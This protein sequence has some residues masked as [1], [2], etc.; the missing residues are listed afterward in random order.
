MTWIKPTIIVR[1]LNNGFDHLFSAEHPE[2]LKFINCLKRQQNQA[3]GIK[4]APSAVGNP[5]MPRNKNKNKCVIWDEKS[6]IILLLYCIKAL[7]FF[8]AIIHR[9]NYS[10]V[11]YIDFAIYFNGDILVTRYLVGN[12][13]SNIVPTGCNMERPMTIEHLYL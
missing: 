3:A 10:L 2:V 6:R 13:I 11:M 1:D 4:I 9:R 12:F 7:Y 8:H 5:R